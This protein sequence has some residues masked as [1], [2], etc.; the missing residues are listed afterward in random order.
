MEMILATGERLLPVIGGTLDNK[1][2]YEFRPDMPWSE[3][4]EHDDIR[5]EARRR[6]LKYR[7]IGVLSRNLR[8]KYDLHRRLYRPNVW[9]FVEV[10]WVCPDCE[11]FD[12]A[13]QTCREKGQ[14]ET[15]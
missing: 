2:F 4:R 6:K 10:K 11:G 8:G 15:R 12:L 13:C 7:R 3:L 5:A 14:N 9:S 1:P